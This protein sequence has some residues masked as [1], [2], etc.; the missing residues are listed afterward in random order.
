MVP[1]G[2]NTNTAS[3]ANI[4]LTASYALT[5]AGGGESFHPFLLG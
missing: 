2:S 1:S 3:Y 4:A 5:S